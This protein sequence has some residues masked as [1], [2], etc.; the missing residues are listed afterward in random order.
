MFRP[1]LLSVA[2]LL[3]AFA[4]AAQA[5][6]EVQV[7]R[8]RHCTAVAPQGWA[9]TGESPAGSAFGADIFRADRAAGASYFIVGVPG[10]MRTSPTYARWYA[11]PHQGVMSTLTQLGSVPVQCSPPSTPTPGLSLMQCRTPQYVGL[12]LYQ[13]FPVA[14][15]GYVLAI[16]TAATLPGRWERE[17]MLA[18]A[19][20]RSIRCNVP[21]KPSSFDYTT[22][23]S[24]SGKTRRGAKGGD[25]QY[26]R[27]LGMEH[28]HD[29]AT[30]RNYWAESGRDWRDNG[31]RGPGFYANVN[32]EERLLAPGRSD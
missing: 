31:P 4:A 8:G 15:N 24:E 7:Q 21:L 3:A 10:E 18:S 11:T 20:S 2:V 22:G 17:G 12:A 9:F 23:L 6:L 13:V 14:A 16:R 28:V 32:G 1:G 27:W 30:G 29:P 25:S 26:S 5:P 19:V